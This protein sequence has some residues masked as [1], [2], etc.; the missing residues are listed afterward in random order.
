MY[1]SLGKYVYPEGHT[2]SGP[3]TFCRYTFYASKSFDPQDVN[4]QVI[5]NSGRAALDENAT[6]LTNKSMVD[7]SGSNNAYMVDFEA[8]SPYSISGAQG[9]G[10]QVSLGIGGWPF[11]LIAVVAVAVLGTAIAGAYIINQVKDISYS[12]AG[13]EMWSAVKWLGIGAAV[14]AVVYTVSRYIPATKKAA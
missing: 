6:M 9:V 1:T 8:V 13:D 4:S 12:P 5:Y 2:Y 3:A 11:W 7:L 10:S 14:V